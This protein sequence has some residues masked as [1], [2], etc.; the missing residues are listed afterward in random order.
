MHF[1]QS[2]KKENKISNEHHLIKKQIYKFNIQ[3]FL[4]IKNPLIIYINYTGS[5]F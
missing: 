2:K 5:E 4:F 3:G 1:Q